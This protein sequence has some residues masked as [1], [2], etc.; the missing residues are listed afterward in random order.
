MKKLFIQKFL[1]GSLESELPYYDKIRSFDEA[2]F[3][4]LENTMMIYFKNGRIEEYPLTFVEN[5]YPMLVR[6][7]L[8][9]DGKP[10]RVITTLIDPTII[11]FGSMH[12][13]GY[14]INFKLK[15]DDNPDYKQTNYRTDINEYIDQFKEQLIRFKEKYGKVQLSNYEEMVINW[16]CYEILLLRR[17]GLFDD[18]IESQIIDTVTKAGSKLIPQYDKSH[19]TVAKGQI[20]MNCDYEGMWDHLKRYYMMHFNTPIEMDS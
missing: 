14:A 10:F 5:D 19:I 4:I 1:P 3:A 16:A 12:N 6:R 2:N 20:R 8:F 18:Q 13:I 7:A 9:D 17:N 15:N 11:T